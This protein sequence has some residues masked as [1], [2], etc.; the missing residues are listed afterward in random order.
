MEFRLLVPFSSASSGKPVPPNA[1][2]HEFFALGILDTGRNAP[3]CR[4]RLGLESRH[5]PRPKVARRGGYAG[6]GATSRP[7]PKRRAR[8]WYNA[9]APVA[10]LELAVTLAT[11]GLHWA[12]ARGSF[13][14]GRGLLAAF[15]LITM[16]MDCL[17]AF[18]GTASAALMSARSESETCVP[19]RVSVSGRS[20]RA[21]RFMG[22]SVDRDELPARS[23]AFAR[24]NEALTI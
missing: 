6:C 19:R 15:A 2:T 13:T 17:P 14:Y 20:S 18:T 21:R 24:L 22:P 7:R 9:P 4:P 1:R 23:R 11:A 10:A 3:R 5:I 8:I 16:A 12:L